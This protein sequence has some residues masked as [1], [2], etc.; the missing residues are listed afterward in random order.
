MTTDAGWIIHPMTSGTPTVTQSNNQAE[1]GFVF[2]APGLRVSELRVT[3]SY[4]RTRSLP[5][6]RRRRRASRATRIPQQP[7][8]CE[9]FTEPVPNK[10]KQDE[11]E[12]SRY[13]NPVRQEAFGRD[14]IVKGPRE[15]EEKND[16]GQDEKPENEH[17]SSDEP[18]FRPPFRNY[19]SHR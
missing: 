5:T 4:R 18:G 6:R 13:Y 10:G 9:I 7:I 19:H 14:R 12:E 17:S 11:N 1:D 3:L 2:R 16:V 15:K 8:S